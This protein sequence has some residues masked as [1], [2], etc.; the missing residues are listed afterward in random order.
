MPWLP[1]PSQDAA[2]YDAADPKTQRD[3]ARFL[4]QLSRVLLRSQAENVRVSLEFYA[5]PTSFHPCPPLE[6]RTALTVSFLL[7]NPTPD[8]DIPVPT[9]NP[10]SRS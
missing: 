7:A 2:I 9:R 4:A 6:G 1:K 3:L 10:A 5:H 8:L